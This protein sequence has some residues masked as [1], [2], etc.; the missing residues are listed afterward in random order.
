[1]KVT[2]VKPKDEPL[3]KFKVD[4]SDEEYSK[5]EKF[6]HELKCYMLFAENRFKD[7]NEFIYY[8]SYYEHD[9]VQNFSKL[10]LDYFN[11]MNHALALHF[12]ITFYYQ[13]NFVYDHITLLHNNSLTFIE[14]S[15]AEFRN[16]VCLHIQ[17]LVEQ[18]L[19]RNTPGSYCSN[20]VYGHKQKFQNKC[21]NIYKE[22]NK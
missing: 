15:N 17:E 16:T 8:N 3:L 22:L 2:W 1:M 12:E 7:S 5:Y 14:E 6:G 13:K 11:R 9:G 4:I 21:D 10:F 19:N 18:L 20:C